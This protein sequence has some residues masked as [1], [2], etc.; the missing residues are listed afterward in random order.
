M[1]PFKVALIIC[2]L[3]A[4]FGPC[5]DMAQKMVRCRA[6]VAA[7]PTLLPQPNAE[8]IIENLYP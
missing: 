8:E 3:H 7:V 6:V 5:V 4:L 1:L 2:A